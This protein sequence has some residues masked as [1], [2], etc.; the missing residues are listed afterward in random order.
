MVLPMGSIHKRCPISYS[1]WKSS[2]GRVP[3]QSGKVRSFT[4]LGGVGGRVGSQFEKRPKKVL[5]K[6]LKK[7]AKKS[8]HSEST[9]KKCSK[10]Y[11]KKY[12]K[13]HFA[14]K[15]VQNQINLLKK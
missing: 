10:K 13:V 8:S 3:K 12:S 1:V 5:K 6:V 4:I 2:E 9:K 11:S 7:S 15:S 14:Q